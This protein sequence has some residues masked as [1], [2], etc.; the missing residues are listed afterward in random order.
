MKKQK[1]KSRPEAEVGTHEID[2]LESYDRD[3][4]AAELRR[5]AGLLG[6]R[7]LTA[8][9]IDDHARVSGSTVIGKFGSMC[10]ALLASGLVPPADRKWSNAALVKILKEVWTRTLREH[11]RR[12]YMTDL[13][14]YGIPVNGWTIAHRFGTWKKALIVASRVTDS[15]EV[16]ETARAPRRYSLS[17]RTRFQVFQRDL[18][19][20]RICKA[21]AVK[22]EVDHIIPLSRG[23][24]DT[25]D[26][27]QT[28]CVPCNQGKSNSLQ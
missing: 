9:E 15:G 12:P 28:L 7:S 16:P 26:N 22:L 14:K 24:S 3:S 4:I 5:V 19:Q 27:L 18:Y 21:S 2:F 20:C 1:T 6:K 25:L 10:N 8:R 17:P 11:G 13:Q 23:G